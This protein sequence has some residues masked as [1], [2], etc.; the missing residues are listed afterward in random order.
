MIDR[1]SGTAVAAG[2][3]WVVVQTGG[4]G[5]K[6]WCTP[7]TAASVRIGHECAL[8]TTLVT[9]EDSLTLYGFSSSDERDAFE[10]AQTASGVGPKLALAIVSVLS[11]ADFA[12][13]VTAGN[14]KRLTAVPG[15]GPKG[16]QKI[17]IELKDKVLRLGH[18]PATG[19]PAQVTG[20]DE[21]WR[22]QV[23]AGLQG[24]GWSAKDADAACERVAPMVAEDSSVSVAVLMRAALRSL[25]R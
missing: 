16:A 2:P 15:L 9:R 20:S 4:I 11:P 6:A 1:L 8:S 18:G 17:I 3:N 23:S 24:L 25:A 22:E 12:A 19:S 14:V 10:L 21:E 13:A 5:L 7:A